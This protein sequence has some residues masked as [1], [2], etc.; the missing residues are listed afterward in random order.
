MRATAFRA[1]ARRHPPGCEGMVTREGRGEDEPAALG[2]PHSVDPGGVRVPPPRRHARPRHPIKCPGVFVP[3][4]ASGPQA[5]RGAVGGHVGV[6]GYLCGG[7][8]G[9]PP[10]YASS[11]GF[12]SL[13]SREKG[14]VRAVSKGCTGHQRSSPSPSPRGG[15]HR[16]QGEGTWRAGG[17]RPAR[18]A[19]EVRSSPGAGPYRTR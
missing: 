5:P 18:R 14:G 1:E 2:V 11:E 10:P 8:G 15:G 19:G 16:S 17:R 12:Y 7:C 9:F 6:S 4:E 3:S 13:S